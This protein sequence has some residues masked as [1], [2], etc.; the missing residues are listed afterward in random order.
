M[1]AEGFL[2]HDSSIETCRDVSLACVA[3]WVGEMLDLRLLPA[4]SSRGGKK[5]TCSV[6]VED[7]GPSSGKMAKSPGGFV[8][9]SWFSLGWRS[10]VQGDC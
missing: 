1:K 8:E 4:D 7:K 3:E 10:I 5:P 2:G 9:M 6:E